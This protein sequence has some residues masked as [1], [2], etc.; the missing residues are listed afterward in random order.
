MKG[1]HVEQVTKTHLEWEEVSLPAL[2]VSV[3]SCSVVHGV[4]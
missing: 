2:N 4:L 1:E 3:L